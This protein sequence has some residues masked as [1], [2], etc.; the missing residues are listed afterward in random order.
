MLDNLASNSWQ[1]QEISSL[2]QNIMTGS[3]AHTAPYSLVLRVL[4]LGVKQQGYEADHS[5]P[6]CSD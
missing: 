1:E 6:K 5:S 3:V 4:S 2:F